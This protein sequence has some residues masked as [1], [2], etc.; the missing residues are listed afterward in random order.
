MMRVL[1]VDDNESVRMTFAAI[2]DDAGHAVTEADSVAAARSC[3]GATSFELALLDVHLGDGLGTAL[4]PELRGA[5]PKITIAVLSG[6]GGGEPIDGADLVL[7]KG[8]DPFQLLEQ[9]ERAVSA[10]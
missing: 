7:A 5:H 6:G 4:I 9:L 3:L 2:L 8:A 10:R 1:L